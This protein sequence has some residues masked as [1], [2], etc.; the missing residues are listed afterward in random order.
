M[1]YRKLSWLF[2]III[3]CSLA[4]C[5]GGGSGGGGGA[6]TPPEAGFSNTFTGNIDPDG[7]GTAFID[8]TLT[9]SGQNEVDITIEFS[10]DNGVTYSTCTEDTSD[11]I[12]GANNT[13]E[14]ITDLL[15]GPDGIAHVFA[16]DTDAAGDLPNQNLN[17]L[18]VR[19]TVTNGESAVS[20]YLTLTNDSSDSTAP[21][22]SGVAATAVQGPSNDQI[23]IYFD[24]PVQATDAENEALYSFEHP[25]GTSLSLP[26]AIAFDYD[27][28]N[29]RTIITLDESGSPN[30][31]YGDALQVT[32]SNIRDLVGNTVQ[33]GSGDEV[34]SAVIGDGANTPTDQPD[35]ILAYYIGTGSPSAGDILYLRFNEEM[36]IVAGSTFDNNDVDFYDSGDT[37]GTSSPITVSLYDAYTLQVTLGTGV[38]ITPTDSRINFPAVNDAITDLAG[39]KPYFSGSPSRSDYKEVIYQD[40]SAPVIDLLTLNEVPSILNGTGDAG[41]YLL[42]PR[43]GFD[44]SMEYRDV[45]GAEVDTNEIEIYN[46]VDVTVSGV[47][48][49][50]GTNLEPYLT[51]SSADSDG[52]VYTV[53]TTM[54]FTD[55]TNTVTARVQDLL[56]NASAVAS[57]EFQV[58]AVSTSYQPFETTTNAS[59]VW[60]LIFTRDLYTISATGTTSI[61]VTASEV[62][63]GTAD[64]EE[65]LLL[66]GLAS[67]SPIAVTGT[68]YNSNEFI[69]QEI[70]D[71]IK[72]ELSDTIFPGVNITFTETNQGALSAAQIEYNSFT[73]SQ[74]AI[75]GD[76][77][78]GAL[79]VAFVDRGNANQDNDVLYNGSA[80]YN[81][82]LH[83]GIF[84]TRLY[85]FEVNGS[86]YGSFRQAFDSF[87]PGR[88]TPVGEGANDLSILMDL[89]GTGASVTGSNATRR[90]KISTA[91]TKLARFIAVVSAH[92]MGHS[93]GLSVNGTMPNGLYGGDATNF[94]GSDSNHINLSSFPALF[95]IP[96]V[97]IM[98]PATNFWLTNAS[99]TRF[100]NL[101]M[102]FLKEKT[103]YNR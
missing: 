97:N 31:Q 76:S 20:S 91:I 53:P 3:A 32:V 4:G 49:T 69:R 95:S 52:A 35:L 37:I 82:G 80:V 8:Y 70:I 56:G 96:A 9:H 90:D 77:D 38:D 88:G 14:G 16:W 68:A 7:D 75:G 47:T 55:G 40:T 60:N 64:F 15:A 18:L 57:F 6:S 78:V 13:S 24:E 100:N 102:S 46:S 79:G 30:L 12:N 73:H 50:A 44:I 92:E 51:Q 72:T 39:N 21:S 25:V 71:A 10:T 81:P 65:D 23:I 19:I 87:I 94:P 67:N 85:K 41:G 1:A 27:E 101:N 33:T 28:I 17:W 89:A 66:F 5:G 54:N 58:T 74:L 26:A 11:K 34:S 61:S 22:L 83:L 45:G 48:V 103:Y 62:A 99:G 42:V 2:L 86:S 63:N 36:A 84:T 93:M 59:Q 43:T 98:I 29:R